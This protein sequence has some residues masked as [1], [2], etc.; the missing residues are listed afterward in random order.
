MGRLSPRARA[1]EATLCRRSRMCVMAV[2]PRNGVN[3]GLLAVRRVRACLPPP[4]W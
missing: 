2:P 1:L 3:A 4:S